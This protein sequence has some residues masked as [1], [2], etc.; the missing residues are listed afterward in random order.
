MRT[1]IV[2][3]RDFEDL[4]F[5]EKMVSKIPPFDK[6]GR[7]N[8]IVSGGARGVDRTAEKTARKVGLGV[9]IF[10]PDWR[11]GKGAAIIRNRK[12]MENADQVIAFWDGKSRGTLN[13]IT[14]AQELGLDI[15]LHIIS[16]DYD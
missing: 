1:A 13:A 4:E 2:G 9:L 14:I 5:V 11:L 3:S 8:V 12:I 6:A 10:K 16:H 7:P 15:D